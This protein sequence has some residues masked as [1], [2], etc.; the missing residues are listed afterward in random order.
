MFSV[1]LKLS[2]F[3]REHW[4]RYSIAIGVLLI[5]NVIEVIPPKV[6]GITIDNIKTGALTNEAIMQYILILL[7]VT[8]GGYVLTFIWQHQLFGGA[9]VL[10]KTMRSKFMGHVL[11]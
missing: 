6:L 1:L 9:F 10:E 11:R 4:K 8:I 7:G 2:W 3:F 5:V